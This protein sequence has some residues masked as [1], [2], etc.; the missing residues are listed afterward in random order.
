M[1]SI[2]Q[3]EHEC[4]ICGKKIGLERHHC[5]GGSNRK[6]SEKY[7]LTVYLC[8]FCHNEPPRGVHFNKDTADYIRQEAQKAFEKTHTRE[9][10]IKIF[11]RNFL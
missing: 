11:G 9:E 6:N 7:G 5:I 3:N 2:V 4:F 10:F 1:K 8:H